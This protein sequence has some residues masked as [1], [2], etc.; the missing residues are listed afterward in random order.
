M[1]LVSKKIQF[2][3]ACFEADNRSLQ[4]NSIYGNKVSHLKVLG[5]SDLLSGK[6]PATVVDEAWGTE[7]SKTLKLYEK[8]KS[9]YLGAFF[10]VGSIRVMNKKQK[11]LAPLLLFPAKL[12]KVNNE[13]YQ[14]EI[15]AFSPI[16]NPAALAPLSSK[17]TEINVV[18]E[19]Y[20]VLTSNSIRFQEFVLLLDF[21]EGNFLNLDCQLAEEYP[22]VASPTQMDK[23]R[24]NARFFKED[25]QFYLISALNLCVLEKNR[26][27]RGI[28]NELEELIAGKQ[29]I[30][31]PLKQ[32]L[33][34]QS[35][36]PLPRNKQ[37]I[38]VPTT[39]NEAQERLIWSSRENRVNVAIGPPGTGKSFTIAALAIDAMVRNE[40][41]LIVSNNQQA[42]EVIANKLER[43]YDLNLHP[44]KTTDKRWKSKVKRFLE[45]I[46]S[47]MGVENVSKKH[48][49]KLEKSVAVQANALDK[50]EKII[51]AR[52]ENEEKWGEQVMEPNL[53]WWK[54][55]KLRRL[56]RRMD[57]L[58]TLWS[59]YKEYLKALD[60]HHFLLKSYVKFCRNYDLSRVV[61]SKRKVLK[62]FITALKARTGSLKEER[63]DKVEF[64]ILFEA[65]PIWLVTLE[66]LSEMVPFQADLFNLV[67]FDE[68]T[69]C[70]MASS[71]P[72]IQRAQRLIVV[73]DPKQLRH[74]S[75]VSKDKQVDFLGQ[76]DL[77]THHLESLDY[78]KKS[79][80]D[81]ALDQLDEQKNIHF[82]NE[83][84]RSLPDIIA[85][86]NEYFYNRG[87]RIMTDRPFQKDISNLHLHPLEGKR[88]AKGSNEVE[89]QFILEQVKQIIELEQ[90][91]LPS[92]CQSIGILS[93]F[94]EQSDYLVKLFEKNLSLAELERHRILIGTPHFF[95][96]E[97][98]D[99][100]FL[101]FALDDQTHPGAFR[102]LDKSDVFNVSITRARSEQHLVISFNPDKLKNDT[103][104]ASYLA[105]LKSTVSHKSHLSSP[106]LEDDAFL[107][108]VIAF[109][110]PI[111]N[112]ELLINY[113]IAG[114]DIDLMIVKRRKSY[115]IDLIGYPG[116]FQQAFPLE[117][118]K[119]L[120]RL[121]IKVFP[122]PYFLWQY[123]QEA[124][125]KALHKF[126][127]Y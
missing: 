5:D 121:G 76:V 124:C 101:S 57:S 97:E 89:A 7:C 24:K 96:G 81:F 117:R 6:V 118:I 19:L 30:S 52:L 66:Q 104:L 48:L 21:L 72:A 114:L 22:R 63:F 61:Y 58:P 119:I 8:E 88:S 83:H 73:G 99:L 106:V 39:L 32:L 94:R 93:P 10:V 123:D 2:Y 102:Y 90:D 13:D 65:L 16:V 59:L 85:F 60:R 112:S 56:A 25:D 122:L 28:M 100:M 95:Q 55:F 82:L 53:N 31:A 1:D 126:L 36:N 50:L 18:D 68:A 74:V 125:K 67:I 40:S 38:Y 9:L 41:V 84:F 91:F 3:R 71:I 43:D 26:S 20:K 70:D 86:S 34:G 11:L 44:I 107:E 46:L 75:F 80:I 77:P 29:T 92:I 27:G 105:S 4:L 103:L 115:C 127:A 15:T 116:H 111:P 37:G 87:L 49:L 54:R 79:L 109:L 69:Q 33:S 108:E 51:K 47:G 23:I 62:H 113:H 12:E 45:T 98:R 110:R 64:K 14:V 35:D 17:Q 120:E 42:I 78:R